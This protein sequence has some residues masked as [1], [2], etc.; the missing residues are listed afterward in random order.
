[1]TKIKVSKEWCM[2]MARREGD[3]EIGAGLLAMDPTPEEWETCP[4]CGGEG[5]IE[6][7]YS[8]S[9]WSIDPPC[10]VVIPCETCGGA[11]GAIRQSEG[12][13]PHKGPED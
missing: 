12:S 11:G 2:E 1:M 10:A 13:C 8:V 5:A 7:W 9:K 6:K 4:D 3:H